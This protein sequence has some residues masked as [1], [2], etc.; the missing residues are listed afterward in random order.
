MS[1]RCAIDASITCTCRTA[2]TIKVIECGRGGE[3]CLN[4]HDSLNAAPEAIQQ[5]FLSLIRQL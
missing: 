4:V 2:I 3:T 1:R 5:K